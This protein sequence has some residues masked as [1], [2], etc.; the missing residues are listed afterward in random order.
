[1]KAA[2][3]MIFDK[4]PIPWRTSAPDGALIGGANPFGARH[5]PY[6]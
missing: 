3:A 1:M 5:E 6:A 2:G 4:L